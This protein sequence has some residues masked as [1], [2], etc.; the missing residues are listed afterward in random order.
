MDPLFE[1]TERIGLEVPADVV[2]ARAMARK[3]AG[4]IGFGA[5]DQTRL[6]TAVSEISRNVLQYAGKGVC[7][8]EDISGD[9]DFS[10]RIVFTDHGPG[11]PDISRA[12][13]DGYSTS[14]GLGCGLPSTRRLMDR[15]DIESQPGLTRITITMT[16]KGVQA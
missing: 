16:R 3:L 9:M 1:T 2:R 8:M 12:M 15:F 4:E 5:A 10:I 13:Q 11:I 6:A 14:G 7:E